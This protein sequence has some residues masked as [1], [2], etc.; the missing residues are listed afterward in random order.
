MRQF[1]APG[2]DMLSAIESLSRCK[3]HCSPLAVGD[4]AAD[5]AFDLD[6]FGA[7]RGQ[8]PGRD[9]PRQ[10]PGKI[11]YSY[12]LQRQIGHLSITLSARRAANASAS[13][14]KFVVENLRRML[15]QQ[16]RTPINPP[17]RGVENTRCT[18]I[19]KVAPEFGMLDLDEVAAGGEL[20]VVEQLLG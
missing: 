20:L 15:T 16:R 5:F 6:H 2:A 11:E 8:D 1:D 10:H 19:A 12:S 18:W 4:R 14:C 9:R 13:N 17:W 3:S 7:H